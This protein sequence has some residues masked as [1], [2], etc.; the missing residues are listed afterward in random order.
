MVNIERG[1]D[2]AG[3]LFKKGTVSL[4]TGVAVR[5]QRS[6]C[7][8]VKRM[9]QDELDGIDRVEKLISKTQDPLLVDIL[10]GVRDEEFGHVDKLV[11]Y[12]KHNC[13]GV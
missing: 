1:F 4:K 2:K 9:Y 8:K 7:A 12:V 3:K 10:Q 5:K 11:D 6:E 13:S